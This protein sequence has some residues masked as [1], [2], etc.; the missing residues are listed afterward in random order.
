MLVAIHASFLL[1]EKH[2]GVVGFRLVAAVH[3]STSSFSQQAT[4]TRRRRR[5]AFGNYHSIQAEAQ[6][7]DLSSSRSRKNVDSNDNSCHYDDDDGSNNLQSVELVSRRRSNKM[8]PPWPFSL[9]SSSPDENEDD[10]DDAE[11]RGSG[12]ERSTDRS[13]ASILFSLTRL[14]A[15]VGLN[16]AKLMASHLWFHLPPAAPPFLLLATIPQKQR[17]E[18]TI[19]DA[20]KESP[21]FAYKRIIPLISSPFARN[22]ASVAFGLA[23]ISWANHEFNHKRRLTPLPLQPAY[24]DLNRVIL[25]PF[26]P[27]EVSDEEVE[28]ILSGLEA[29]ASADSSK[30]DLPIP[31]SLQKHWNSFVGK[32]PNPNDLKSTMKEWKRL[33]LQRK[34]DRRNARRFSVYNELLALQALKKKAKTQRGAINGS[35]SHTTTK[36]SKSDPLGYALVTGA[37]RG[38]GRA[39]AVELAR[40]EIPLILVARD[41]E[42][43]ASLAYDIEACY[44]VKCC[45]L[46]ADLSKPDAAEAVF[47]TTRDAGLHVDLLV[48]NAGFSMQG[49]SVDLPVHE[50]NSMVQVNALSASTLAHLYGREMKQRRRGRILMMSS[51]CGAVAGLPTVSVY[52]ATKAFENSL[53]L[54][55]SKEMEQFGVGVTLVMPGAVRDTSFKSRSNTEQ[56]L[57]W[58]LPFY[59]K[60]PSTIASMAVRA[61][62]GGETESTPGWQNRAFVKVLKPILPQRLHNMVAETSWNPLR[63][64]SFRQRTSQI[65]WPSLAPDGGDKEDF[66]KYKHSSDSITLRPRFQFQAPP[67]LLKIKEKEPDTPSVSPVLQTMDDE[68]LDEFE[69]KS[70]EDQCKV[71]ADEVVEQETT[72]QTANATEESTAPSPLEKDAESNPDKSKEKT[73]PH[74]QKTGEEKADLPSPEEDPSIIKP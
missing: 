53:S 29:E 10:D 3:A 27:D 39:I 2:K 26:L 14:S 23:I 42:R 46:E 28:D 62:L 43:L 44:G 74:E 67:R 59:P 1:Q 37:S 58:R 73:D 20:S 8:W 11:E 13:R 70:K 71:K 5:L 24:R 52:A 25:P 63:F 69:A 33:R 36:T 54:G 18:S 35:S 16:K 9:L 45:I 65:L 49:P 6:Y 34:L 64:P 60:K 61:T 41:I 4:T 51:I 40:Y 22:V 55:L 57:C 68:T 19:M 32:A 47:N 17:I 31:Q 21:E 66:A 56:A 15:R 30:A 48:N 38:I 50:L 7:A 72:S 12:Y